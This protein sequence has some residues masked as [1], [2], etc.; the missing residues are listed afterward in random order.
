MDSLDVDTGDQ[1]KLQRLE[2]ILSKE[3]S[4]IEKRKDAL[5]TL[6][7]MNEDYLAEEERTAKS[8]K[9]STQLKT[10]ARGA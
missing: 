1:D 3:Q 4:N 6:L 2:A 5:E 9:I 7:Q 10:I 8:V